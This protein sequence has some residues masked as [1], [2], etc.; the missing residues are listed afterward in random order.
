MEDV[1]L[2]LNTYL[3]LG[4]DEHGQ[5]KGCWIFAACTGKQCERVEELFGDSGKGFGSWEI[6]LPE[7]G[8]LIKEFSLDTNIALQLIKKIEDYNSELIVIASTSEPAFVKTD[9]KDE[10]F[11]IVR[12]T[13]ADVKKVNSFSQFNNSSLIKVTYTSR[14]WIKY[15]SLLLNS[16]ARSI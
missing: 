6:A 15:M 12:D 14:I 4:V 5:D 8:I 1:C 7:D 3:V 2:D 10:Y 11:N 13:Y 9:I 16:L